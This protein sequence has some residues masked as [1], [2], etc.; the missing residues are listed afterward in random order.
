MAT[1]TCPTKTISGYQFNT[2]YD[3]VDAGYKL[4]Y[5]N[6]KSLGDLQDLEKKGKLPKELIV[7][8]YELK[9]LIAILFVVSFLSKAIIDSAFVG[10]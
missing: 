10:L 2:H 8:S 3:C 6:F 4:A 1:G 9:K 5:N 7:D